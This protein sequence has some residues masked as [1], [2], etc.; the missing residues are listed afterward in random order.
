MKLTISIIDTD[1]YFDIYDNDILELELAINQSIYK[2]EWI[3]IGDHLYNFYI[4]ENCIDQPKP[5]LEV[6][7]KQYF[8]L[9]ILL[10][11]IHRDNESTHHRL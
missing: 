3:H 4:K 8:Y 2:H 1:A 11:F 7:E 10:L 6:T 5:V 9:I